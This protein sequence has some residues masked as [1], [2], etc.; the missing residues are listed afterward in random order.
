MA[1]FTSGAGRYTLILNVSEVGGSSNITNNTSNVSW[2]LQ[3]RADSAYCQWNPGPGDFEVWI[4]GGLAWS[5]QNPSLWY[6]GYPQ[7]LTLA[8]GTTT[9]GHNSDGS[10]TVYCEGKY[11]ANSTANYLPS[12]STCG[13]NLGLSTIPRA[14]SFG[15]I[16][17]DTI[18]DSQTINISRKSSSFT[19][20]LWYKVGNGEWTSIGTGIGTSK[21]WTIPKSLNNEI[22]N[23]TTLTL[24]YLL[25]TYNGST[26]IGGDVTQTFNVN[27]SG[28]NPPAGTTSINYTNLFNN[29]FIA[30]YSIATI[31]YSGYGGVYGSTV[32]SAQ[33]SFN[34]SWRGTTE[35]STGRLT[36]GTYTYQGVVTDSRGKT[37]YSTQKSFTSYQVNN[38]GISINAYRSDA[39]GNASPTGTYLTII[40]TYSAHNPVGGNSIKSNSFT[41]TT[42]M[43]TETTIASGTKKILPNAKPEEEY[44][45]SGTVTDQLGRT[46]ATSLK[47]GTGFVLW[48]VRPDQAGMAFGKYSTGANKFE[49]AWPVY[50][51]KTAVFKNGTFV[52]ASSG[53]PGETGFIKIAQIKISDEYQNIPIKI[54]FVQRNRRSPA[55]LYITFTNEG[56]TDPTLEDSMFTFDGD[57]S[58]YIYISKSSTSTWDLY[59]AKSEAYDNIGVL[60][61]S[62]NYNYM[63]G[64]NITWQDEQVSKTPD[65]A[66]KATNLNNLTRYAAA[67]IDPN[68]TI[69]P[70]ILTNH[71]NRPSS[72]SDYWYITTMFYNAKSATANRTQIAMPYS[73][74]ASMYHR[75]Y[76]DGAWS[77]W[78]R[79]V[80]EDDLT[81]KEYRFEFKPFSTLSADN[82]FVIVI[83]KVMR[84]CFVTLRWIGNCNTSS[85]T[86]NE[87]VIPKGYRPLLSTVHATAKNVSGT[88]NWGS[89]RYQIGNS[90]GRITFHTD[91]QGFLERF[92][93]FSYIS[94]S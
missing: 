33:I 59:V 7:T 67:G 83:H 40:P 70:L 4:N 75:F 89:T 32:K 51:D 69:Y 60:D 13:G 21:T 72:V 37:V 26:Q 79:L 17:G 90:D 47:V 27:Y 56:N 46:S 85:A 41:C 25:R 8:S 20:N 19:H 82:S 88:N 54:T 61:Y 29:K 50:F 58:Y 76:H 94:D 74:K 14:S 71:A 52:H 12:S 64:V 11:I 48:D 53:T 10:K 86:F 3:M 91:N 2:S 55:T 6:G 43:T 63:T 22:P 1:T 73:S 78:Q 77:A 9:V 24:T 15:T 84:M 42:L 18:G 80:N 87:V 93:N 39:E 65:G 34:G 36:A 28:E 62:T 92:V 68:T 35:Y 45:I 49:I 5:A 30:N 44:V 66:Q 23:S 81:P 57:D 38:P 16:T 31:S